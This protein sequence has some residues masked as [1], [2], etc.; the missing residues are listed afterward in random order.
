MNK[1]WNCF[2]ALIGKEIFLFSKEI[3]NKVIDSSILL[4][5]SVAVFGYFMSFSGLNPNY[6]VFFFVSS[7]ASFGIYE[8]L[9][10]ATVLAQDIMDKK[11]QNYLVLPLKASFI[12]LAIAL[13]WSLTLLLQMSILIPIGKLILFN[14]LQLSNFISMRFFLIFFVSNVFYGAFA[15]WI[16]SLIRDLRSLS[17][18]G[19]RVITPLLMFSCYYYTWQSVHTI[20]PSLGYLQ[21][22]NPL[23][24]AV[25]GT[26]AAVLGQQGFI[27]YWI[28][29]GILSITT[30]LLLVS[31]IHRLKKRT[32]A[33]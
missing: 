12:F 23:V 15:L 6:G 1:S 20:S 4:L 7:I 10:K 18:I 22:C 31:A 33:I 19:A 29:L 8:V 2:L 13:S 9:W 26:R 17:W 28:C 11:I 21:L 3:R 27:N 5:T 32:H 30:T 25:E 14:K 24:Y 16:A